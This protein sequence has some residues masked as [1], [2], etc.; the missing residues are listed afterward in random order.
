[1]S[2]IELKVTAIKDLTPS[3]KMFEF[4]RADGGDL[5]AF[6]A[7][8]HLDFQTGNGSFDVFPNKRLS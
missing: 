4:V 8:S 6:E 7:G 1:M 5:P 2:E 3:I